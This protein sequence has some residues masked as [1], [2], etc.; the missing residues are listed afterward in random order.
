MFLLFK[1]QKIHIKKKMGKKINVLQ[2]VECK[3]GELL[4]FNYKPM[5]VVI[6]VGL[7]VALMVLG[8]FYIY[9]LGCA[10]SK[11]L[12]FLLLFTL[13]ILA[14]TIYIAVKRFGV[15]KKWYLLF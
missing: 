15:D 1:Q 2:P 6:K 4:K 11:W 9:F 3:N 8:T 10:I 13:V 7:H 5:N 12:Y 14:D